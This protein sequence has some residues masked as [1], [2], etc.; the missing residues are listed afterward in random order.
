[1]FSLALSAVWLGSA[2]YTQAA[3]NEMEKAV[4]SAKLLLEVIDRHPA[5]LHLPLT[6]TLAEASS[7]L[8]SLHGGT[9]PTSYVES[10][11]VARASLV[12]ARPTQPRGDAAVSANRSSWCAFGD[13]IMSVFDKG[14]A[15]DRG[16]G[17]SKVGRGVC[18]EFI[19]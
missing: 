12:F 15:P 1:M 17:T 3:R 14:V 13:Q 2:G 10:L 7:R 18:S 5:M 19:Y 9:F 11:R 6:Y 16:N 8:V 4:S